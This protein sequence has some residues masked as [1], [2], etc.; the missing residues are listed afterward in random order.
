MKRFAHTSLLRTFLRL[1]KY[2][3]ASLRTG[4]GEIAQVL[5]WIAML[6]ACLLLLASLIPSSATLLLLFFSRCLLSAARKT[7]FRWPWS[8]AGTQSACSSQRQ[9]PQATGRSRIV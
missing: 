5:R 6:L 4:I 9:L 1:E 7:S 3:G 2:G 8:C